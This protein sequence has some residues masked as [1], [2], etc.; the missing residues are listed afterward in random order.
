LHSDQ[1]PTATEQQRAE[2]EIPADQ[3]ET[4]QL[5]AKLRDEKRGSRVPGSSTFR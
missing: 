3:V 4:K 1:A 2:G 5:V